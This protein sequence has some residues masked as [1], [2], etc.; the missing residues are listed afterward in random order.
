MTRIVSIGAVFYSACVSLSAP[1]VAQSLP[2]SDPGEVGMSAERLYRVNDVIQAHV[3][4]GNIS[5]AGVL[6]ARNGRVVLHEAY[7]ASGTEDTMYW[8]ASM[9][10]NIVAVAILMEMEK[11]L[12]SLNDPASKF[13]PE[14]AVPT[15]VREFDGSPTPAGGLPGPGQED[16]PHTLVPAERAVLVRDLLTHSSG[17]QTIGIPNTKLPIYQP[18][19]TLESWTS[20]LGGVPLDFQPGQGWGYSNATGF[21]VLARI[22]EVT[23]GMDFNTYLN[24]SI[25]EPLGMEDSGFRGQVLDDKEDQLMQMSGP[26]AAMLNNPCIAGDTF[27]CGSA[28]LWMSTADYWRFAQMLANGGEFNG[29]RLLAPST[30]ERMATDHLYGLFPSEHIGPGEEGMGM[31]LSVAV[32]EDPVALGRMVPR[33]AFGWDGVGQRR[34]WVWPNE[35]VVLVMF[36]EGN[37]NAAQQA[38]E[39]AVLQS[40]IQY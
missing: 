12:L 24:E 15:M 13:I 10:K 7:G 1:V 16:P 17:L 36:M 23:S 4:Q 9:T 38:V 27:F 14:L 40:I 29:V 21:D 35:S 18:G 19:D 11:G 2:M 28:G 31:G 8:M 39:N 34:F 3:D 6:V 26:F 33:G 5:D 37:A 30:V 32:V 22:V 20:Q 25:F